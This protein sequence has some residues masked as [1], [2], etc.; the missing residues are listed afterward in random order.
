MNERHDTVKIRLDK[1]LWAARF[2]KTRALASEAVQGGKVHL[3]GN[4]VKP[5]RAVHPGDELH[6]RRGEEEFTVRVRALSDKRG[7]AKQAVLLYEETEA[8][9][10]AREHAAQQR[11]LLAAANPQPHHR[12]DKKS[13]RQIVRFKRG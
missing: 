13:R 1:W 8:S 9:R 11:R 12:P 6:I 10:L 5:A 2:F 4:R 7:P 3:N